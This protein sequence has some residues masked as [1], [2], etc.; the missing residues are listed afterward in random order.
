VDVGPEGDD[1]GGL[2]TGVADPA[3]APE[4]GGLPSPAIWLERTACDPVGAPR[5]AANIPSARPARIARTASPATATRLT[6]ST[7]L[8]A[9]S[10]FPSIGA[11]DPGRVVVNPRGRWM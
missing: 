6:G 3:G 1:G 2:V 10:G 7:R 11:S 4:G 8:E 9:S 5:T